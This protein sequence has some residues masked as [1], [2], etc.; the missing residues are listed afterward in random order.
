M[1]FDAGG[2][3]FRLPSP[4]EM[5]VSALR[6]LGAPIPDPRVLEAAIRLSRAELERQGPLDLLWPPAR[7]DERVLAAMVALGR[8]LGLP[9]ERAWYLRDTCYLMHGLR[10]YPDAVPALDRLAAAGYRLGLISNAP[11]SLRS[12]LHLF[13]LAHRFDPTVISAEVDGMKPD[14]VIY[15]TAL[16][17]WGGS[18]AAALFIDD[19]QPNVAAA[20]AAGMGALHLVR[21][22][23][24]DI[25]TLDELVARL[26]S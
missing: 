7:E 15:A 5:I 4:D 25:A 17:R 22:G 24:G 2:V 26:V 1:F 19:L 21:D 18:P 20:R 3:L 6:S 14:A 12:K 8:A 11:P 16:Q 10:L 9:D 13:G 23:G